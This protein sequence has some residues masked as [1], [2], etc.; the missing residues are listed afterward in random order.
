MQ[1]TFGNFP[2]YSLRVSKSWVAFL[3][4]WTS[5]GSFSKPRS[6]FPSW[7]ASC[8]I[9]MGSRRQACVDW[10]S[11]LP[12]LDRSSHVTRDWQS[13]T[14]FQGMWDCDWEPAT[15]CPLKE[16]R[17]IH[18]FIH[19]KA[20]L[21]RKRKCSKNKKSETGYIENILGFPG[22]DSSLFPST[23]SLLTRSAMGHLYIIDFLSFFF[24]LRQHHY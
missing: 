2:G 13:R 8:Q 22:P 6:Q 24:Y 9:S 17:V 12:S 10:G 14:S 21:Q 16:L 1:T 15:W 5:F 7:E 23:S 11:E 18:V 19:V 3:L 4:Y 20:A